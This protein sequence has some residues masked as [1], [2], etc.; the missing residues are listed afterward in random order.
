MNWKFKFD[1]AKRRFGC[2]YYSTKTISLSKSMANLN[3]NEIKNTILHEIAHILTGIGNGHNDNCK[4]KCIELVLK[5]ERCCA[6]SIK[7]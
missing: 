7:S 1:N 5:P 4:S 2:C 6:E 3:P